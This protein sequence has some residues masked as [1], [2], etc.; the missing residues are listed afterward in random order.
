MGKPT[1][2]DLGTTVRRMFVEG[3]WHDRYETPRAAA[4]RLM[5]ELDDEAARNGMVVHGDVSIAV[6]EPSIFAVP[7]TM[8]L[9]A[10][11]VTR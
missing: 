3:E 6:S 11:V 2:P 5:R 8:R 10:D 9:E 7:R 4:Q 1:S